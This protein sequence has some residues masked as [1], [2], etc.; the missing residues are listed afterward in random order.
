MSSTGL[1]GGSPSTARE[2]LGSVI[3]AAPRQWSTNVN[4]D[5]CHAATREHSF[6]A[7]DHTA[8]TAAVVKWQRNEMFSR[9]DIYRAD[10]IRLTSTLFSGGDWHWRLTGASGHVI[11]DCG[12]YRN[13]AQCLAV[14]KAL[15]SEAGM[16]AIFRED[17][18][19]GI[20]ERLF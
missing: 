15:R 3:R 8:A 17:G 9:F 19:E 2:A 6:A 20:S 13:E 5:F 4:M 12:G 7:N 16:A 11:A 10:Q 1:Y 18:S 14:V